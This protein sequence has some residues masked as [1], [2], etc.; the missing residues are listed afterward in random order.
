MKQYFESYFNVIFLSYTKAILNIKSELSD[1]KMSYAWLILEPGLFIA[2]YFVVFG[3]LLNKGTENFVEYL[4]VGLIPWLWF[5]RSVTKSS[6]S[7]I[8]ARNTI[9]QIKVSKFYFVYSIGIQ[10]AIKQGGIILILALIHHFLVGGAVSFI[11]LAALMLLNLLFNISM[12]LICAFVVTF[13]RDVRLLIP[14]VMRVLMYG[15]AIVYSIE[16]VPFTYHYIFD[17]NPIFLIVSL[18][19]GAILNVQIDYLHHFSILFMFTFCL[20]IISHLLYI[21]FDEKLTREVLR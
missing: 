7:L 6:A 19:R 1:N 13:V 2:V 20:V 15:S 5:S 18:Y 17:F 3:I 9:S 8:S 4:I 11:I 10:E 16:K 12:G 21:I 14:S